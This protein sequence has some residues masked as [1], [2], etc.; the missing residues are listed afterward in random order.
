M[1]APVAIFAVVS[2]LNATTWSFVPL[3]MLVVAVA[4]AAVWL[5]AKLLGVHLSLGSW[6]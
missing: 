6:D 4:A 5:M 1:S 2:L 3:I